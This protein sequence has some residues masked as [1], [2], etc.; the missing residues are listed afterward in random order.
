M[1]LETEDSWDARLAYWHRKLGRLRLDAEPLEDQLASH[2][3]VAWALTIV[4]GLIAAIFLAI[5]SSFGRPDIGFILVSVL[6]APIIVGAW[7]DHAVLTRRVCR[8][9][10]E[11]ASYAAPHRHDKET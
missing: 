5:F 4:P 10:S 11:R 3:R 8:F 9:E 2:R 6:I 1:S 7:V